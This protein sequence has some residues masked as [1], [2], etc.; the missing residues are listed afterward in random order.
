MS[1]STRRPNLNADK[2]DLKTGHQACIVGNFPNPSQM[3]FGSS[4]GKAP[5]DFLGVGY[6]PYIAVWS[7]CIQL[8]QQTRMHG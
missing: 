2:T 4:Y 7:V 6:C 8:V 1:Y 5:T 3:H